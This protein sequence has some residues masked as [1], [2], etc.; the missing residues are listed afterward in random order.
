MFDFVLIDIY[1][2]YLS[3]CAHYN[4]APIENASKPEV[5]RALWRY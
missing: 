1:I 4:D 3:Y 5:I 2:A